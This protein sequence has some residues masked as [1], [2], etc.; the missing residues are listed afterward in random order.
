MILSSKFNTILWCAPPT[1]I[2]AKMGFQPGSKYSGLGFPSWIKAG[3]Q[4]ATWKF[5][6]IQESMHH[7]LCHCRSLFCYA[8]T[9]FTR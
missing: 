1:W 7:E 4:L 6:R 5:A 3:I 9:I 2:Q 8:L